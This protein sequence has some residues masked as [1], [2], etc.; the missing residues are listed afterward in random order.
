[1]SRNGSGSYSLPAGNPVVT[2]TTISSTWAN[3]TLNDIASALTGSVASDG[4]TP[5]TG[6]LAMG[7]NN[8]TNAGTITATNFAGALN[9]TVGATTPTTGA[10]TTLSTSSTFTFSG[11][12]ASTAL[13]LDASK[14]VVSVTNTGTGNNVLSASPTLTGTIAGASLSLSSLTSGRIT[15]AGTSGLLQD[16]STFQFTGTNLLLGTTSSL[17]YVPNLTA[18]LNVLGTGGTAQNCFRD[19]ENSNFWGGGLFL[20]KI[21]G[22]NAVA[23]GVPLG[24]VYFGGFDGTQYTNTGTI[25]TTCSGAVSSGVVPVTMTVTCTSGGVQL[26][27]TATSWASASDERLKNVTGVYSNALA[28]IDEIKPVKFTW[29]NDISAK[30][31]VGILAQSV[32]SVVP[33]AVDTFVKQHKLDDKNPDMTEYLNVRYTELI[34]LMIASIQELKKEFEAY[35]TTHP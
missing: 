3:T 1:M 8:I 5:M 9:G 19:N 2:G 35:K 28:L 31:C 22:T 6:S 14:N 27:D 16:S 32:I 12:T 4:Q 11:L 29:K 25:I 18:K 24:A 15:Y 7:A 26:T 17:A 30:P 33:E 10:F 13:A 23:S 34:P 20:Q 21:Q